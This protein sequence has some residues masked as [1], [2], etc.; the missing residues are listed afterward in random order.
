M[1]NDEKSLCESLIRHR[2]N[3]VLC[4][5][6]VQ[7]YIRNNGA[8]SNKARQTIKRIENMP[9][10]TINMNRCICGGHPRIE[11]TVSLHG[12]IMYRGRCNR[13]ERCTEWIKDEITDA[14]DAWNLM[15]K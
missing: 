15:N 11:S 4:E 14:A 7:A 3:E 1:T 5:N 12:D 9:K 8:L 2:N 13:C 10:R 6:I